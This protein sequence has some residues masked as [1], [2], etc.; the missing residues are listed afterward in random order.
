M[1]NTDDH[2]AYD[3]ATLHG[4]F[5]CARLLRALHWAKRKDKDL[6]SDLHKKAER[7]RQEQE[8]RAINGQLRAEAAEIAYKGWAHKKSKSTQPPPSTCRE[9]LEDRSQSQTPHTCS[10]CKTGTRKQSAKQAETN[11]ASPMK[12]TM[13]QAVRNVE[14]TGKPDKMHPYSN[15][16]PRRHAAKSSRSRSRSGR[17]GHS[18]RATNP[19]TTASTPIPTPISV[20]IDS[21]REHQS[22]EYSY[23][24]GPSELLQQNGETLTVSALTNEANAET[25]GN[26]SCTT[27][28]YGSPSELN[29]GFLKKSAARL[30][31]VGPNPGEQDDKF[32][33]QFLIG[34]VGYED[35]EEEVEYDDEY[36]EEDIAFH[37]VGKTNSLDSLS[38]P[39]ALTK[40]RTP[41]EVVKLLHYLGSGKSSRSYSRSIS[42]SFGH[43]RPSLSY[44][45]KRRFS[46]GAI[47]EGQ[48]VTNYSNESISSLDDQSIRLR[49][50]D[51]S[52]R[53][54]TSWEEEEDNELQQQQ[55]QQQQNGGDVSS[56]SS[57][58]RD[59]E[60]D[61]RKRTDEVEEKCEGNGTFENSYSS[62]AT[63]VSKLQTLNIVNFA[64]DTASNSVQ[65]R[66]TK[67]LII[68]AHPLPQSHTRRSR[69]ASPL[70]LS[71]SQSSPA[72]A[73]LM[74]ST[75]PP[76]S[77][78]PPNP[79]FSRP[80]T[81]KPV[82]SNV[83]YHGKWGGNQPSNS[84]HFPSLSLSPRELQ[85]TVRRDRSITPTLPPLSP[86]G[87]PSTPEPLASSP[88]PLTPPPNSLFPTHSLFWGMSGLASKS[89]ISFSA[90]NTSPLPSDPTRPSNHPDPLHQ[91]KMDRRI[92]SAPNM[93]C[94]QYQTS[95]NRPLKTSV[96]VYGGRLQ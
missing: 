20:T 79:K 82:A 87:S 68:P 33:V 93:L 52:L 34:G 9:R 96:F 83:D 5:E 91:P 72:I 2:T 69:S 81:P 73:P 89:M 14:S 10:S 3:V 44:R 27:N 7:K 29:L 23:P 84:N 50:T 8:R 1:Q 54:S 19:S 38:L 90:P 64:W 61:V 77:I 85:E 21:R 18:S 28:D 24:G 16:P 94:L 56:D 80:P 13:H 53:K 41:A 62:P 55:Q 31:E 46:L 51:L 63:V 12:V 92:K 39:S 36:D 45:L 95:E 75:T 22:E 11:V 17:S 40:D 15:Y 25:G 42:L 86:T 47:P 43:R 70:S 65:T 30:D 60:E 4:Q 59:E 37:D 57:F 35:E 78:T 58:E 32:G 74:P 49:Y 76:R 67:S 71:P 26:V 48:M 6:D 88:G 66:V